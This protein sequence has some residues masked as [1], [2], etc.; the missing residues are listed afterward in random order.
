MLAYADVCWR[1]LTYAEAQDESYRMTA[2]VCWRMLTYADVCWRMLTY[3][4]VCWRML[5]FAAGLTLVGSM[6]TYADVCWRM[7]TY[8]DGC[9]RM[10]TDADG[11]WR[12]GRVVPWPSSLYR[13]HQDSTVRVRR[14]LR[15]HGKPRCRH[16]YASFTSVTSFTAVRVRRALGVQG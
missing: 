11:C 4:D 6:L 8:A 15:L 12:I 9:W 2:S 13:F 5:A 16:T 10:L 7:L 3:A 1:M 14:P